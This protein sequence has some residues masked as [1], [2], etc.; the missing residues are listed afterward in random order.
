MSYWSVPEDALDSSDAMAPWAKLALEAARRKA[1]SKKTKSSTKGKD[2][3]P[4]PTSLTNRKQATNKPKPSAMRI[5][6]TKPER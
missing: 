6:Q 3:K 5:R 4:K 1:A 2:A